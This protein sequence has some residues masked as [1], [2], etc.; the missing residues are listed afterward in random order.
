MNAAA[1]FEDETLEDLQLE[2]LKLIQKKKAFRF[3]MD[4][5]LLAHF[6]EIRTNDTVAD[7]GCGNGILPLLLWGRQKG[8]TYLAVELMPEAAELARRNMRLNGLETRA[9]VIEGDVLEVSK[10]IAPCSLDAA[11]C[12]PPYG[13]P[14]ASLVSPDR[15]IAIARSQREDTLDRFFRGA[16]RILKGRGKLSLVYPAPQ[17]LQ[18]MQKLQACHLEPKRFQLVYPRADRPANL[19]LIEAVKDARPLLHPLPP[20]VI[21]EKDGNL[22]NE[23]KSVYH[24]SE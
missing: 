2:G 14:A 12:N 13:L 18:V 8:K 9:T 6:A 20:L 22:T 1:I 11:V 17:M 5:V 21:Y 23:L 10:G 24:I 19:V 3:G 16:Y 4:A 15:Q 7:L